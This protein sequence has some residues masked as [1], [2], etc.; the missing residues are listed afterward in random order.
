VA[1]ATPANETALEHGAGVD[2]DTTAPQEAYARFS[3]PKEG[4]PP[5]LL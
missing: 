2:Q 1:S 4:P 3:E 5:D